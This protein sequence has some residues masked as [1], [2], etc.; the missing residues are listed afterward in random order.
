MIPRYEELVKFITESLE[1][2]EREEFTR[3]KMIKKD[4]SVGDEKTLARMMGRA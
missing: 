4:Q 1:E 3:L 2:K